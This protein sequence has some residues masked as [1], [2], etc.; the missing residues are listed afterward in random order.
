[1]L[2]DRVEVE[3]RGYLAEKMIFRNVLFQAKFIKQ[4]ILGVVGNWMGIVYQLTHRDRRIP[5]MDGV[6]PENPLNP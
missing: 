3:D 2:A 1:M 4:G 5:F 6:D